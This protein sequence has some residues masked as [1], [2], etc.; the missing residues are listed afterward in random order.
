MA[1]AFYIVGIIVYLLYGSGDP[2]SW[3]GSNA[4]ELNTVSYDKTNDE[5][6]PFRGEESKSYDHR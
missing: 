4:I 2:E 6:S 3:N 5:T 1:V